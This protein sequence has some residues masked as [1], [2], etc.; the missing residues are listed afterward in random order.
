MNQ[1][2]FYIAGKET[3]NKK[4]I[5]ARSV[6]SDEIFAH[7]S[8]AESKDIDDALAQG[9]AAKKIM[10]QLK[11]HQK[12]QILEECRDLFRKN[13]E[14]LAE[15]ITLESGKTI[16]EAR[17]E[18]QRVISVFDYAS[19]EVMQMNGTVLSMDTHPS[20]E[21]F[22]CL[23]KRFPKG[24]C[25][26]ITPFNFP[27]NLIAHKVAPAIAAGC[28]FII[29]PSDKTPI[30]A[31]KF[32]EI[33]Q[34]SSLPKEAFSV[35]PCTIEDSLKLVTDPRANFLSFTGSE[36]V[37]WKL[38]TLA[39]RKSVCL[40]LGGTASCVVYPDT[41]LELAAKE[42]VNAAFAQAGQSCISLQKLYIHEDII[43]KLSSLLVEL[44]SKIKLGNPLDPSTDLG[45]IIN[46]DSLSRITKLVDH[47]ISTGAKILVGGTT[48]G[49]FFE[50]T[51][52]T[53]IKSDDP[54][55]DEEV[56]APIFIID[57]FSNTDELFK[58]LNQ[59]CY[60]IHV[61]IYSKDINIATKAW[62]ELEY[63]AI[64]I[65]H[66][67]SWR[68]DKMPYGGIKNSGCGREGISYAIEEMTE[69]KSLII[70]K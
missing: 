48:Q 57:T 58:Q 61:G 34:Q 66:T 69:L 15:I 60:G 25:S 44:T 67:P 68:S 1:Y 47:S 9:H 7:Y 53:N 13:S 14:D 62:D 50:A 64:I 27:I 23:I 38:K 3:T 65:G 12:R 59:S 28:P 63:T 36:Q 45:P 18:M 49:K 46:K 70:K 54:I 40:E 11:A 33:L 24:L 37:G 30:C 31:L 26:F 10:Q 17:A 52:L 56:F 55:R 42:I 8:L 5:E 19:I 6:Y 51:I 41:D 21:D 43:D 16:N 39:E 4:L 29:K 20:S 35:V 22:E 2:P 32:A